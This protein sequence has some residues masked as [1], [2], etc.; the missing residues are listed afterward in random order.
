M[1]NTIQSGYAASGPTLTTSR[2]LRAL[3]FSTARTARTFSFFIFSYRAYRTE[4]SRV[5]A[6]V[7]TTPTHLSTV[8]QTSDDV[9]RFSLPQVLETILRRKPRLA[10]PVRS[11]YH[12]PGFP[13]LEN[14][15]LL[16]VGGWLP[17]PPRAPPAPSD[18]LAN[19]LINSGGQ[20]RPSLLSTQC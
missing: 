14:E 12:F 5:P 17:S 8:F 13:S 16:G 19:L 10:L 11:C 4:V 6:S 3:S 20:A 2:A 7:C 1:T 9:S 18:R 15:L